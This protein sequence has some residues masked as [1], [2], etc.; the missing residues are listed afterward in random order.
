MKNKIVKVNIT[1]SK[2]ESLFNEIK[3]SRK[4]NG[5]ISY[6]VS[7]QIEAELVDQEKPQSCTC[8]NPNNQPDKIVHRVDGNPCYHR[9]KPQC[10]VKLSGKHGAGKYAIVDNEDFDRLNQY[11]WH[12]YKGVYARTNV[13]EDGKPV[14]IKMHRLVM[15]AKKGEYLDHING[16]GLDNRKSNLRFCTVSQNQCNRGPT[17]ANSSGYKGVKFFG[18]SW[19]ATI[20]HKGKMIHLGYYKDK[21]EAAKAYNKVA[22]KYH[23]KFA[24]LN[25]VDHLNQEILK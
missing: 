20:K 14:G 12:L 18:K 25:R 17:R 10:L 16:N 8:G 23:G 11:S 6:L 1:A 5:G 3:E 4:L 7:F 22:K 13:Y 15:K 19:V 21:T 2:V 24:K 9:E